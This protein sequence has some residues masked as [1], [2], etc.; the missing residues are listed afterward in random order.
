DDGD[1]A[2][3]DRGLEA[4]VQP[5]HD[6][7]LVLLH[8]R[9]VDAL[10]RGADADGRAVAG[11]IRDLGRVQQRLGRDTATMQAGPPDLVLLDQRHALAELGRAE[12]AGLPAAATAENDDVVADLSH[13]C[14]LSP[15]P[16]ASPAPILSS[17]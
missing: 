3:Q 8:G 2:A 16:G 5:V 4:L 1:L 17:G 12:R 15:L 11:V 14:F 6:A 13:R 9:H 7:V 10:E